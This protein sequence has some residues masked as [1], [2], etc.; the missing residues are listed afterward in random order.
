MELIK[1]ITKKNPE[2]FKLNLYCK[3]FTYKNHEMLVK[4]C[5]LIKSKKKWS[6]KLIGTG[7]KQYVLK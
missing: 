7:E 2:K 3:F 6:L 5:H 4:A 1:I